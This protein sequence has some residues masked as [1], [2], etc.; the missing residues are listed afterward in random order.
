MKRKIALTVCILAL[1]VC[2]SCVFVGCDIFTFINGQ[3]DEAFN[4]FYFTTSGEKY[5][6]TGLKSTSVQ[7]VSIP[8]GVVGIGD[9][10]FKQNS[11]IA[12]VTLTEGV[13]YIGAHAFEGCSRMTSINIPSTSSGNKDGRYV[14]NAWVIT[15][16]E[17]V[18]QDIGG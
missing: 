11:Q 17:E 2:M 14:P 10:A 3:N 8:E 18:E 4:D 6:I 13:A 15:G 7:E 9:N 16:I 1:A 12:T 5:I